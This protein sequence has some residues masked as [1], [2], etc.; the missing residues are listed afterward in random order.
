MTVSGDKLLQVENLRKYFLL[1][2]GI[3]PAKKTYLKAVD[4]LTFH[5]FK[6]ETFGLVGESGCGKTTAGRTIVRLYESTGGRIIYGGQDITRLSQRE[7]LPYRKRMQMIFQ[8]PYTSLNP[9][10]T[11][12]D[13]I[14]ESLDIHRA[15]KGKERAEL[16]LELMHK[17]GL[18]AE[19]LNRYPHQLSGG[20]CQRIGI[21]R[22]LAAE[23]EFIV[24]DEPVSA[25]DVSVRAQ[26]VNL[27][28]SLQSELGLT[29]LFIAHDLSLVRYMASRIGVMYLGR[30]VEL[31]PSHE[32]YSNPLHPYTKNLLSAMPVPDPEKAGRKQPLILKGEIS[33]PL[34]PPGGCVFRIR[35]PF[36]K[37]ICAEASPSMEE[38][39]P[40]HFVVCNRIKEIN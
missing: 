15:A 26:V 23:P 32:L 22:S 6:R 40:E 38:V 28:L 27:L 29:Y 36:A 39:A 5:I 37:G 2:R 4:D 1:T 21:A 8:D 20:Q 10:M 34:S 33:S 17:V 12:G 19:Y 16:I 18:H 7:I 24:C 11:A 9:R 30:L 3:L 13:I 31:A 14:G 25:L 35:C